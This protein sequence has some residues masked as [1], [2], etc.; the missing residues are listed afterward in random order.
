MYLKALLNK[1]D[2]LNDGKAMG[3]VL[4]PLPFQRKAKSLK[5]S[6]LFPKKYIL[7]QMTKRLTN[8][9]QTNLL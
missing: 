4:A 1:D 3:K 6:H 7:D 8:T 2:A 5:K 9:I